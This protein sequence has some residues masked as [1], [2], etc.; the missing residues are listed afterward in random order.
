MHNLKT[1]F[2]GIT[3]PTPLILASGIVH[4]P[5]AF[6]ALASQKGVG[7]IT[8][9][10][11]SLKPRAGHPLPVVTPYSAGF[12]NSVGLKN[13]GVKQAVKEIR[14]VKKHIKIPLLASI[15]A[16]QMSEFP[17][18][19]TEIAK[20]APDLIELNLSCPNVDDEIGRP[21]S[22]DPLLSA[23]AVQEVKR[24]VKHIPVIA[25][26]TPNVVDIKEIAKAV[27]NAGADAISAIN[28]VGPGLLIDAKTRKAKLGNKIGGISGPSIKPLALRCVWDIAKTVK[29]PILGMGG[30]NNGEDALEMM[31]AGATL[32][33]IGS[34]VFG[35]GFGIFDQINQQ[36][37]DLMKIYEIA[38]FASIKLS[39]K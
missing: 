13:P 8:W 29:I 12:I 2:C 10:S 35:K 36:M 28:T 21:F 14:E 17:Q 37:L 26:L 27:E 15:V 4:T 7:G 20:A 3:F 19:A 31:M 18:L 6:M 32:V 9:K 38:S 30:V 23:L 22:T 24:V 1:C 25:K 34:A 16:F 11:I 5:A 39:I 33:G